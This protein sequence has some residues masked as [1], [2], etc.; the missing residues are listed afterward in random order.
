MLQKVK[1]KIHVLYYLFTL[2]TLLTLLAYLG[3]YIAEIAHPK[4]RGSFLVLISFFFSFG[5]LF[6]WTVS[7][8]CTWSQTAYIAMVAPTLLAIIMSF[9][10]ESPFWLVGENQ[11]DNAK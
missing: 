5:L 4:Y 7:Y 6:I 3:V 10:P 1:I 11:L 2:L 9:L 8:F